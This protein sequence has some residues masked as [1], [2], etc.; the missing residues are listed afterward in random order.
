M[1]TTLAPG[2]MNQGQEISQ[3]PHQLMRKHNS[4]RA[5]VK[6][7]LLQTKG[8]IYKRISPL[9]PMHK[10]AMHINLPC[11][12]YIDKSTTTLCV[13]WEMSVSFPS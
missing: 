2:K 4:T 8:D 11:M 6:E 3:A 12:D 7:A 13:G 10:Y 1:T 5:C 9:Y